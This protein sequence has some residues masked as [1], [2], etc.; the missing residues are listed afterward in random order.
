MEIFRQFDIILKDILHYNHNLILQKYALLPDIL[1]LCT[2]SLPEI[3]G[4]AGFQVQG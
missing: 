1:H 3:I 2:N 4:Q